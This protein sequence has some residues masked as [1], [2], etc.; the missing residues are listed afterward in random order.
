[1][2]FLSHY[3]PQSKILTTIKTTTK[4]KESSVMEEHPAKAEYTFSFG[5]PIAY[6]GSCVASL[7][8]HPELL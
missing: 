2:I 4:E 1:M 7:R 5:Y 8:I 6:C 3:A